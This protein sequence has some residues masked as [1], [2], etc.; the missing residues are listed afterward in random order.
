MWKQLL[1]NVQQKAVAAPVPRL[2]IQLSNNALPA[3]AQ[4]AEIVPPKG[5]K[6]VRKRYVGDVLPESANRVLRKS[7]FEYGLISVHW[8]Q[9]LF[10]TEACIFNAIAFVN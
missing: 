3:L 7:I 6:T 1:A 5:A 9:A 10:Q 4:S 8:F 2:P